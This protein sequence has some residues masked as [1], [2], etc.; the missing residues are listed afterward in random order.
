MLYIAIVCIS[1][2]IFLFTYN[3][4]L[5]SHTKNIWLTYAIAKFIYLTTKLYY[6]VLKYPTTMYFTKFYVSKFFCTT[7]IYVFFYLMYL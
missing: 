7:Y 1:L 3:K 2:S 5:L 4:N 6:V